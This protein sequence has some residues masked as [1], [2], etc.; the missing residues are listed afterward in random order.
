MVLVARVVS[1]VFLEIALA[2][3]GVTEIHLAHA[4]RKKFS[5]RYPTILRLPYSRV[6]QPTRTLTLPEALL[7]VSFSQIHP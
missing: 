7:S 3:S 1:A 2:Q 4:P 6:H 5:S